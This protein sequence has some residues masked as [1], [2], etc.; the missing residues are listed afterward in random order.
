MK[1]TKLL[2]VLIVG[3][4]LVFE[5]D[6]YAQ[7]AKKRWEIL[8]LI[9]KEKFDNVL[10]GALRDNTVDMWIYVMRNGE[11]LRINF[12]DNHILTNNGVELLYPPNDKILIK[13]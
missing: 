11:K 13:K 3:I 2:G 8:D 5:D 12:E 1:T 7:V 10:P 6:T 9:R 4:V